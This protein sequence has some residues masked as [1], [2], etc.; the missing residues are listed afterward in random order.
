[1]STVMLGLAYIQQLILSHIDFGPT[2]LMV[3]V[4]AILI[5]LVFYMFLNMLQQNYENQH[6]SME[7]ERFR[8]DNLSAQY[9][10][11]NSR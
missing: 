2:M 1:M 10:L 8:N 9:D 5:N 11:L 6:V 3:E 7:L 4:R